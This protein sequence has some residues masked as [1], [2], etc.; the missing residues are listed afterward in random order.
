VLVYGRGAAE[1]LLTTVS[2]AFSCATRMH[3]ES[4][5]VCCSHRDSNIESRARITFLNC[6]EHAKTILDSA[7]LPVPYKALALFSQMRH[8]R[9]KNALR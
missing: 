8:V 9:L 4:D 6:I 5:K 2:Y 1:L 3:E 7:F